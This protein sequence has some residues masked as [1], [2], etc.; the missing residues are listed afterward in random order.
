MRRNTRPD[1]F[2]APEEAAGLGFRWGRLVR[3]VRRGVN[4]L[5]RV[6]SR[7]KPMH[8]NFAAIAL[9]AGSI[10][11]GMALGGQYKVFFDSL[12]SAFGFGVEEIQ[13]NG[14]VE[15][16]SEDIADRIDIGLHSS[17]LMLN[18]EKARARIAEI[19]W[20]AD[21]EVKKVYPDKLVVNLSERR[22]FALWQD[23]GQI[24]VVDQTGAVMSDI[25]E[26][27]HALLP[28]IVGDGANLHVSE[29]VALIDAE[30][31]LKPKVKAAQFVAERRWNLVTFDGVEI[32]LPEEGALTAVARVAELDR[33][34]RL[35]DRDIV[36]VDMRASDRILI[37]LSDA[38]ADQRRELIKSRLKKKA[39]DT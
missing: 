32:R 23:G 34:K 24:R 13:I 35:L 33:S 17:L 12:S 36:A 15:A 9:L 39:S 20:V 4:T 22:A 28:L 7:V 1:R 3:S 18:A 16:N 29:A 21:V 27:R 10:G 38:A 14:L 11:Y 8:G 30:P 6:C 31:A 5:D 37:K 2:A 25:V 19:P 26:E